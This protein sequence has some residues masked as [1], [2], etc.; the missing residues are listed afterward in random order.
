MAWQ[1][2]DPD[3]SNNRFGAAGEGVGKREQQG[4]GFCDRVWI[5]ESVGKGI[6]NGEWRIENGE[7][8]FYYLLFVFAL[9][10]LVSYTIY[11]IIIFSISFNFHI[12]ILFIYFA[13]CL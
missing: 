9:F 5:E 2:V 11:F 1:R 6:E 3:Q 8:I 12:A 4:V 13:K 7:L 10:Y